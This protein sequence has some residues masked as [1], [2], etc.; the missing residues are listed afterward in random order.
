MQHIID[1]YWIAENGDELYY[2]YYD[3]N[4]AEIIPGDTIRFADGIEKE[5]V[6]TEQ[7]NLGIDATNPFWIEIGRAVPFEYGVYPLN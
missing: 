4:G 7:G 2:R 6:S 5:V 3:K 1:C